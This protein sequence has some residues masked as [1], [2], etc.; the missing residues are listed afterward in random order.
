MAEEIKKVITQYDI[1][2]PNSVIC[3][4]HPAWTKKESSLYEYDCAEVLTFSYWVSVYESPRMYVS[5]A[6]PLHN[7][8]TRMC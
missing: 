4:S 3:T 1:C 7:T 5:L 6:S 8:V 2:Q